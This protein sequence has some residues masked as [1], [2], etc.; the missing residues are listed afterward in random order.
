M[1]QQS[2]QGTMQ[3]DNRIVDGVAIIDIQDEKFEYPKTQVLKNYVMRLIQ[4]G[5]HH[6]VLN[7]SSVNILDSFGI[8]VFIS[9]LKYCKKENGNLT[10]YGLN[11]Q[12]MHLMELT[13]MDRV[14]DIWETEGQA[15]A[16]V[17][18]S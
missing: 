13:R 2:M 4:D 11:D 12:V 8:A 10:M 17:K 15:L 7:L 14:L 9:I 16:H 3:I 6:L 18:S 5:H 1:L